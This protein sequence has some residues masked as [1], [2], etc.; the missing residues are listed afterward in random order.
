MPVMELRIT[1]VPVMANL[2]DNSGVGTLLHRIEGTAEKSDFWPSTRR[3]GGISFKTRPLL[4]R[5]FYWIRNYYTEKQ[6]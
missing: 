4:T 2:R 1:N 3:R 5:V 6:K